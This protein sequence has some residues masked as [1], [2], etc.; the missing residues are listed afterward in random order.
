MSGH[1]PFHSFR[2]LNCG[3]FISRGKGSHPVRVLDTHVFIFLFSGHLELYEGERAFVLNAGDYLILRKGRRHGPMAPYARGLSFFWLH[4][5]GDGAALDALPQTG[6]A[7]RPER[8]AFYCQSL[9][10]EQQEPQMDPVSFRLLLELA[11]REIRRFHAPQKTTALSPTPLA[12]A[13]GH[14]VRL[15]YAEA[16][17]PSAIS[18]E[19]HCNKEYLARLY[20][21]HFGESIAAAVN[22]RRVEAAARL[23]TDECLSVKEIMNQVGFQDPAYFRRKFRQRYGVSP[24][25]YRRFL[26]TG[27][28]NTE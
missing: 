10:L 7:T 6:H 18:R 20:R 2:P 9:L 11:L 27:H 19:L 8:L 22:R 12:E 24:T 17:N 28:R 21:L 15:R 25:D 3:R 26:N 16:L 1:F 4:F 13:A 5:Q 23:L 14:L